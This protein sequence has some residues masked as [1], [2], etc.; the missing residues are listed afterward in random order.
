M[1]V[2]KQISL[3]LLSALNTK[4]KSSNPM[5]QENIEYIIITFQNISVRIF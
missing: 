4:E 1:S 5:T 2:L 3:T